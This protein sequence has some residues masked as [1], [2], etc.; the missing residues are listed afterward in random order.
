[1][2]NYF[3]DIRNWY[4]VLIGFTFGYLISLVL[5]SNREKFPISWEY[6]NNLLYPIVGAILVGFASFMW[7]REQDK[8]TP[9]V[10]DMRDV[11]V[12]G[13]SAL[14]GGY[15]TMIFDSWFIAIPLVIISAL[16]VIFKYKK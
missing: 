6:F 1:M 12:S 11:Y 16:L 8:I 15:M 5:F 13:L 4:H 2:K 3:K 9:D 7:E 10:S 14:L